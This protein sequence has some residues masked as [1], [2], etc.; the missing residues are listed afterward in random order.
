MYAFSYTFVL[1]DPLIHLLFIKNMIVTLIPKI[2]FILCIHIFP[3]RQADLT[4]SAS[5]QGIR[6]EGPQLHT[7]RL[8]SDAT[9]TCEYPRIVVMYPKAKSIMSLQPHL[10]FNKLCVVNVMNVYNK[11]FTIL[12][13]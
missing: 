1:I 2:I 5:L 11:P 4:S 7:L 10:N 9:S 13:S 6:G 3:Y 8:A 12:D